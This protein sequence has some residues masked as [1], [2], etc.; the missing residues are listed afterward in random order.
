MIN[1][2]N[3]TT[4]GGM[5]QAERDARIEELTEEINRLH[6]ILNLTPVSRMSNADFRQCT[7]KIDE[8]AAKRFALRNGATLEYARAIIRNSDAWVPAC[9][10]R[11][12]PMQIGQTRVLY[13]FNP[14]EGEHAYINL[15]TDLIC[16]EHELRSLNLSI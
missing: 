2:T 7:H 15:D 1:H 14:A 8:L 10:G 13:C 3:S 6:H 11:E 16:S 5:R 4:E 9:G 12:E